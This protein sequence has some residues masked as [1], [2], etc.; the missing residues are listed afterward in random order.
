M[1]S[2]A[3]DF[4]R[5][6]GKF[7]SSIAVALG[8]AKVVGSATTVLVRSKDFVV[9]MQAIADLGVT[10]AIDVHVDAD[11]IVITYSTTAANYKVYVPTCTEQGVRSGK[12]FKQYMPNTVLAFEDYDDQAEGDFDPE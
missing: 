1:N 8:T 11:A 7:E 10:T 12:Y 4:V 2:L 5:R 6:S 3:V 9:A